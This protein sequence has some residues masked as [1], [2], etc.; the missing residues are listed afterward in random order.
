MFFQQLLKAHNL[1]PN[2]FDVVA[3][4]TPFPDKVDEPQLIFI[5]IKIENSIETYEIKD[6]KYL[7]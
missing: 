1:D 4:L 7:H 6:S 5:P 2:I 3:N